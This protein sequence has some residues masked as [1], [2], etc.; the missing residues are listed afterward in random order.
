M[1]E[2]VA[3]AVAGGV[4]VWAFADWHIMTLNN[5][6]DRLRALY[7]DAEA[8]VADE[9]RR[10]TAAIISQRLAARKAERPKR[11]AAGK[12]AAINHHRRVRADAR[13]QFEEG[14]S[15]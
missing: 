7:D 8:R 11:R 2:L 5:R 15:L 4:A 3:A 10:A 6:I 14:A 13:A 9:R 1:I 12:Q